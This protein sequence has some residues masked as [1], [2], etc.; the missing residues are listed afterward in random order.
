MTLSIAIDYIDSVPTLY[1]LCLE[2]GCMRFQTRCMQ[3]CVHVIVDSHNKAEVE[4]EM[5]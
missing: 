5:S 4:F 1:N 2:A 3:L